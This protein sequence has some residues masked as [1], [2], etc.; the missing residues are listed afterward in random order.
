M[1]A[2]VMDQ[3][4]AI[5]LFAQFELAVRDDE[6]S[7]ALTIVARSEKP[8]SSARARV[9][10]ASAIRNFASR[11]RICDTPAKLLAADQLA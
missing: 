6:E 2:T 10:A 4:G 1:R 8:I 11:L 9:S 3:R 7:I 5:R